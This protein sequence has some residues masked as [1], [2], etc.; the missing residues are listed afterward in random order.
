MEHDSNLYVCIKLKI[1]VFV[2]IIQCS[3]LL[4]IDNYKIFNFIMHDL[5]T[6]A[7]LKNFDL[8]FNQ[9]YS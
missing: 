2:F 6:K 4:K 5:K 3:V 7:V 1:F 8:M 9:N